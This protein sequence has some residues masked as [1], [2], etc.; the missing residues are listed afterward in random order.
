MKKKPVYLWVLLVLSALISVMSLFGILSPLPS[1]E[2]LR[3]SQPN[4]EGSSTQQVEDIINYTYKVAESSHSIFNVA[5]IVLSAIL[6]VV[7]IAFLV[8]KN[9]QYANY[10]Y[11]AYLLLA[12]VGSVYDYVIVQDAATLIQD[13]TMRL[14]TE[15]A[16]K[17]TSIFFIVINVLFLALVFYKMWR[18]QK[19]LT[20]E[21]ETEKVA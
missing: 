19:S 17:G 4:I 12:I 1:K 6:V 16:S 20:D 7:A 14:G 21:G 10:A 5:L 8:R 18:Q 13:G 3:A 11:I 9:L 2:A 15:V